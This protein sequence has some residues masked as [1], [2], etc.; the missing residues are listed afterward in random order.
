MRRMRRMRNEAANDKSATLNAYFSRN[1]TKLDR[2]TQKDNKRE[3]QRQ[4]KEVQG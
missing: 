2:K 3:G 1:E 4:R